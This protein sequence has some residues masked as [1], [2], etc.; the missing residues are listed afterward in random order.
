ML[1]TPI[2]TH[3]PL[4]AALVLVCAWAARKTPWAAVILCALPLLVAAMMT[5][6]EERTRLLAYGVIVA[7]AYGT[8]AMATTALERPR[9]A[10]WPGGVSPPEIALTVAGIILFRWI[11]LGDV[12]ILRELAVL[13][14]SVALLYAM[15]RRR[16]AAGPA[17]GTPAFLIGVLIVAVATPAHAGMM[18]LLP[19]AVALLMFGVRALATSFEGTLE[20][21]SSRVRDAAMVLGGA[22]FLVCAC[23]ARYSLAT[24]YVAVALAFFVPLLDRMRFVSY[25]AALAIFALWPWSGIVARSLPL[26][27]NYQP[28]VGETL[29]AARALAAGES[30]TIGVP[31]HVRAAVVTTVGGHIER[32]RSGRLIGTIE[33]IDPHGRITRQPIRIG[34]TAD[35]GFMRREQFFASRNAFPRFS[36]G[37]IRGYGASAWLFA[38]GRTTIVCGPDIA[39]LRVIAAP[40]LHSDSLLQVE[41]VEF[42]PR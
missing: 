34:D 19:F 18:T 26:V 9:P 23:F 41:S 28:A 14:G 38:A 16:D 30:L 11:P 7:A 20:A 17:G 2:D 13:A 27:R 40:D 36:P 31:P 3:L 39:L 6:T 8:A 37:E 25:A 15:P 5:L 24:V 21:R 29:P 12:R 33:A 10:G 42:P 22:L 32:F 4:V 1:T 35:F